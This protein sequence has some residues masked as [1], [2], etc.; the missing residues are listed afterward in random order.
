MGNQDAILDTEARA[1]GGYLPCDLSALCRGAA[2]IAVSRSACIVG[3]NMSDICIR[4]EDFGKARQRIDPTPMRS[5]ASAAKPRSRG[6][7]ESDSGG[8][9][10]VVG[11]RA[12][13]DSLHSI[14]VRPFR[15]LVEEGP[16]NLF[17]A[18]CGILITGAPGTGKTYTR[19]S[20][21]QNCRPMFLL[22]LLQTFWHRAL[23]TLKNGSRNCLIQ[24]VNV[25]PAL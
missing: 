1:T 7:L 21:L 25:H 9:S 2:L 23:A 15:Q 19:H 14:V 11:Q 16:T 10:A 17:E 4:G 22:Q 20:W 8:L 6:A 13:V 3:N 5:A 18:P 24:H 12:A